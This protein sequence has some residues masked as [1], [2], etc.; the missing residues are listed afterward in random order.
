MKTDW[1]TKKVTVLDIFEQILNDANG[2]TFKID[3]SR[4][5]A[6]PLINLL[7]IEGD[8]YEFNSGENSFRS[9]SGR[10]GWCVVK[11]NEIIASYTYKRS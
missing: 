3:Y 8:L 10:M 2:R 1:L 6:K 7:S 4:F 9:L 5:D 11:D